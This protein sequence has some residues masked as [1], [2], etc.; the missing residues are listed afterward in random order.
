MEPASG[1]KRTREAESFIKMELTDMKIV[2]IGAGEKA[3]AVA[4]GL[5]SKGFK[6][7]IMTDLPLPI[8]ER[9]GVSFSEAAID[10][11][12]E[13]CGVTCER[14]EPELDSVNQ[15]WSRGNIPLLIAPYDDFIKTIKPDIVI[16]AVMAKKNTGSSIGLAPLVI[17]LGPGF[18]AGKDAHYVIETNPGSPDLGKIIEQGFTDEQTDIPTEVLG[19]TLERL[20]VSPGTGTLRV[21]KDVGDPVQKDDV[22]GYVEDKKLLAPISGV[23][24]GLIRTPADVKEGQKIGDI[25]P[26]DDRE[27][28]FEITPQA[29]LI[30]ESVWKA[31]LKGI[32]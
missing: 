23:I 11:Q 21:I 30:A 22:I 24:W 2:I 10:Q 14:V 4:H 15:I 7:L 6:R 1:D 19:M 5:F 16:Y 13:V 18:Y 3:S 26:G 28:C 27:T 32:P 8:A 31:I 20:L 12:K 9:K 29:K 25:Y 17:A